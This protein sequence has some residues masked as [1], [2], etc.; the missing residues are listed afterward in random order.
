MIYYLQ[1][2]LLIVLP[3]LSDLLNYHSRQKMVRTSGIR[4]KLRSNVLKD[5]ARE[6]SAKRTRSDRDPIETQDGQDKD[7]DEEEADNAVKKFRAK[8][9]NSSLL[10]MLPEPKHSNAFGPTI[11][12]DK[13]LKLP[14]KASTIV[15]EPEEDQIQTLTEDGMVEVDIGKVVAESNITSIKDLTVEKERPNPVVLPKG[16]ERA[17]NQITYLAQLSKATEIERK[18]QAAQGRMNKA[19]ARSKYGW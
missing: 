12:L 6:R 5:L 1:N 3:G 9:S 10:S 16:K 14:P 2:A 18:E 4:E 17:K 15:R 13:L 7:E 8:S 11:K 19:A